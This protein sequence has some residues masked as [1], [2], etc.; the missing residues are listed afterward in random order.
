MLEPLYAETWFENE[1][2]RRVSDGVV[3]GSKSSYERE[4]A[5]V[6][7]ET[8]GGNSGILGGVDEVDAFE[9]PPSSFHL[10]DP[11]STRDPLARLP[12]Y[13]FDVV[14]DIAEVERGAN[15]EDV[16]IQ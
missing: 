10:P 6:N 15:G 2:G 14:A 4:V 9:K 11:T 7:V 5:E 3:A 13:K 8:A 1:G 12:S 16:V